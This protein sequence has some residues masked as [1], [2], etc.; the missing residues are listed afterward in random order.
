M[1]IGQ[2]L[3]FLGLMLFPA[4]PLKTME[5]PQKALKITPP[6]PLM[7]TLEDGSERTVQWNVH[8]W[9]KTVKDMLEDMDG[10]DAG[11]PIPL[12]NIT[13]DQYAFIEKHVMPVLSEDSLASENKHQ[14]LQAQRALQKH[15][16]NN[17]ANSLDEQNDIAKIIAFICAS[18]YLASDDMM[19]D[20][21]INAL[22]QYLTQPER[23]ARLTV[24]SAYLRQLNE[25]L[26]DG[27]EHHLANDELYFKLTRAVVDLSGAQNSIIKPHLKSTLIE[28]TSFG[29]L[30]IAWS[31]NGNYL[32][33]NS[34]KTIK[35]WDIAQPN[36][37]PLHTLEGHASKVHLVTWSPDGKFLASGSDDGTIKIWDIAQH[38]PALRHTL[39]GNGGWVHSVAWSP[40]GNYLASGS[41]DG[42]MKIW[43][44]AQP[45]PVLRHTLEGNVGLVGS[46][47]WSADARY[48]SCGSLDNAIK[49][50]DIAQPH[51]VLLHTLTGHEGLVLSVAWSLDG[52]YLASGSDDGTIKIWDIAQP[53]PVLRHTLEG[54]GVWV[55]SV[56]WSPNGNHL[57]SCYYDST[58]KV[59]DIA[60]PHP[61][62]LSHTF[63]VDD[64]WRG[65]GGWVRS[66]A[67]SPDGNDIA[68]GSGLETIHIWDMRTTNKL[69][70]LKNLTFEQTCLIVAA[71]QAQQHDQVLEIDYT[72]T[73][74]LVEAWQ[75]LNELIKVRL[76]IKIKGVFKEIEVRLGVNDA[77]KEATDALDRMNRPLAC[78]IQ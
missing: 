43:D 63:E 53:H 48:L 67:W 73:P 72:L 9:W 22:A 71:Y 58:I 62:L 7:V 77:L 55:R 47:A 34:N 60:L 4:G 10:I 8:R 40:D 12:P 3:L 45:H 25:Y 50:W 6:K 33:S 39:E 31:P 64:D 21:G 28:D 16:Y 17:L 69:A 30:S 78:C 5:N 42:T 51:P 75:M 29:V 36:P 1:K 70:L 56:A 13:P 38:Y 37:V 24:N 49:I 26:F 41:D 23:M 18:N 46:V 59:W 74:D 27:E 11:S 65:S 52:N 61:V 66:V 32:A 2:K 57:A 76:G 19:L 20:A 54:N 35:I 15:L 14:C 68:C 44:I